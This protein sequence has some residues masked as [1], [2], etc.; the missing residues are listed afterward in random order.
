VSH[1]YIPLAHPK[2]RFLAL[3]GPIHEAIERVLASGQYIL[4]DEM[5]LFVMECEERESLQSFLHSENVGT[6]IHYPMAI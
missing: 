3:E 2:A 4:G 5:H 1:D 6:A